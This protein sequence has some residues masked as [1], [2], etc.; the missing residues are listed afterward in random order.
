[1]TEGR[2]TCEVLRRS[3]RSFDIFHAIDPE[4]RPVAV[5]RA[6]D[7]SGLDGL[8]FAREARLG[9]TLRHAG[10]ATLLG[11]APDWI[12]VERLEGSLLDRP[13]GMAARK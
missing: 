12:A 6:R 13:A 11:H 4:G 8:R 1:M 9:R 2:F 5:K 3:G 7:L 10:L